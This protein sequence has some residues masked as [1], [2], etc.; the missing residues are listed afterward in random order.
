MKTIVQ[1]ISCGGN[2]SAGI[3]GTPVL[4]ELLPPRIFVTGHY[5][6][7]KIILKKK[8]ITYHANFGGVNE[9]KEAK[10]KKIKFSK[11]WC[12]TS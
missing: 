12:L 9:D 1:N 5:K 4:V 11:L 2:I 8:L 3:S 7:E 6:A 10:L